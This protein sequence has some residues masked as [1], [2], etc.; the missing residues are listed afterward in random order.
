MNSNINISEIS[1]LISL[2]DDTDEEVWAGVSQKL[3]EM[4]TDV[5]PFL[6]KAWETTLNTTIQEKLENIIQDIQFKKVCTDLRN[7]DL[8]GGENLL[9]GSAII[10]RM[11]YPDLK[12]ESLYDLIQNIRNEVWINLN[13]NFTALEKVKI[14]NHILYEV[15]KYSGNYSNYYA[16]QNYYINQVLETRKGNPVSLGIIYMTLAKLLDMPVFG[17]NLPK[18]FILAYK[19]IYNNDPK[20]NILFYINP[21]NKGSVLGKREIDYFL[22]QQKIEPNEMYY[23]PCSNL[24][25]IERLIHNLINSY[26]STGQTDKVSRFNKLLSILKK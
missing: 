23:Y 1:A 22:N 19:D 17:I 11:Q 3:S 4:D 10:A 25:I 20:S 14:L 9:N 24:D 26:E 5:I 15:F 2:L 21:Y 18:N 16:P 13:D 12:D 6:E 8:M 7:W